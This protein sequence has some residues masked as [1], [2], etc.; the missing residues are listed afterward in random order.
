MLGSWSSIIDPIQ[1]ADKGAR[2]EGELPVKGLSRLAG[3]CADEA[4]T[5]RVDLQFERAPSDGLRVMHGSIGACVYLTCQRCMERLALEL[6]SR[7]RVLL[8]RPGERE[9]L[10]EAG[11]ALVIEHA[12]PLGTLVEEELLLEMPMA[13]MHPADRCP[14]GHLTNQESRAAPNNPFSVLEKLKARDR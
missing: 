11:E 12:V 7:P 5:V 3:M 14:A 13:P 9:D 10:L 1:L 6:T 8:L 4:G 2:L